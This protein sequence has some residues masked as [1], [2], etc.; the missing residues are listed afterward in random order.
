M[1]RKLSYILL[2][3]ISLS[4]CGEYN[5][6]LKSSDYE[7]KYEYAKKYFDQKKYS[8]ASTLLEEL[9]PLY[10]G[11]GNAEESLYLLARSLFLSKDYLSSG[12][13]FTTYYT[14]YPKGEY[15]EL[16]RF[17]AGQGYFFDSPEAKLDQSQ[18]Y[19]AMN[20]LQLFLEYFPQSDKKEEVEKMLIDLQEKL[21]YKELLNARLYYDLGDYMGDNN[22]RSAVITA[23]NAIKEFP[24]SQLREDF[25]FLVLKSKYSEATNS[26]EAVKADRLRDVVD[27]YYNYKNEYPDGKHIKDATSM[28]KKASK[29][30]K[31]DSEEDNEE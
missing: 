1:K 16:A 2:L 17:Y 24:Y 28:F 6:L 13:Y 5:K 30:I 10:K 25:Y 15:T 26:K 31:P 22:F 29:M 7:L 4:S 23:Q 18:T 3:I 12:Q 27:E 9:V 20:E 14:T 11:T 19:K 21:A 8:K